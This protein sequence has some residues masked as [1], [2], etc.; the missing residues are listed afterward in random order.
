MKLFLV[1]LIVCLASVSKS[2]EETFLLANSIDS[3]TWQF[4]CTGNITLTV[5]YRTKHNGAPFVNVVK[6]ASSYQECVVT[7]SLKSEEI[8]C[9]C[10]N[11]SRVVCNVTE[12]S[13]DVER[14]D[15]WRCATFHDA[16]PSYS[17]IVNV[18]MLGIRVS[19]KEKL[20]EVT[21]TNEMSVVSEVT[22]RDG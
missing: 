13:Q 18:S 4:S 14:I 22:S 21:F 6:V 3:L 2:F 8:Q 15:H 11:N 19:T 20:Q 16:D 5:F 7:S 9:N 10:I 12:R 1:D 17:N